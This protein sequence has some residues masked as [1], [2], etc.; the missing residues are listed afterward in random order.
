M[1]EASRYDYIV[2]GAGSA[3]C[4][5]AHRLTEDPATTVLL[6]EAGG[7]D[8]MPDIHIP[9]AWPTLWRSEV[10]WAYLTEEEP[11]LAGRQIFWPRGKVLGGTSAIN[12]M[13]YIRGHRG[14]FDAW[15][16][17]GNPGWGYTEVLPY[18]KKSEDQQRGASEFHGVGGP[19]AVTD[20]RTPSPVSVAFVEAAVALGYAQNPDFNGAQQEGAGLYQRTVK[21]GK[22]QSTAVAFLHPITD[23]PNLTI[24]THAQVCRLRWD[25]TRVIGAEYT[26]HGMAHRVTATKEVLL[27]AGAI[28][29]PKL[30]LLSGIG[31]ADHLRALGIPIVVD[32]PGVGENLHDHPLIAV[33]YQAAQELPIAP[34]SNLGEAGLFLQTGIAPDPAGPDLQFHLGPI[35][36]VNPEFFR[37]GPGFTFV[38]NVA[39]PQSRGSLRLRSSNL[40]DPPVI[41]ANYLQSGTDMVLL[42]E[43]VKLARRL[44]Q[45]RVLAAF[46]GEEIAPGLDVQSDEAIRA[47]IRQTGDTIFHPVGTCKMGHDRLA[48]VNSQLQVHGVQGL[49]VVDASIM[50][51]ITAGNTNAPT[52]MIG[53]KAAAMIKAAHG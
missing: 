14:D 20:P 5:L 22:R 47:Y 36:F 16:A 6:L 50:P 52:I 38:L 48:V 51:T 1:D 31:P 33:G 25:G 35:L 3:G 49:R 44:A 21:D 30:L 4:V 7:P 19:L 23:R 53:E 27:S 28:D 37:E 15:N 29:S 34:D 45:V 40:A 13:V 41:R 18:F 39:H 9:P 17:L 12:A 32:L 2:V 26:R 8:T 10:D 11:Q 42:V 43:G 46:R 24:Q